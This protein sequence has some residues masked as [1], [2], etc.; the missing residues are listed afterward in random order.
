LFGGEN[1][2]GVVD[3]KGGYQCTYVVVEEQS[4]VVVLSFSD[5]I[6]AVAVVFQKID[7]EK[8]EAC[9]S[10]WNTVVKEE[11][12]FPAEVVVVVVAAVAAVEVVVEDSIFVLV[13]DNFFHLHNLILEVTQL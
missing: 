1:L 8:V 3:G 5:H 9:R 7:F 13:G 6:V 12:V 2:E 4:L 11:F 10:A